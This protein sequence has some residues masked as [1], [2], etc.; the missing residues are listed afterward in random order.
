MLYLFGTDGYAKDVL[1]IAAL[2]GFPIGGTIEVPEDVSDASF[3]SAIARQSSDGVG[4]ERISAV[5]A[6]EDN[7]QRKAL[8]HAFENESLPMRFE[9]LIHPST[10]VSTRAEIGDGT[11]LM[12]GS[13]VNPDARIGRHCIVRSK[14]VIDPDSMIADFVHI[15]ANVIIQGDVQIGE[16]THIHTGAKITKGI[17][18]GR[19]CIIEA[20]AV[21]MDNVPDGARVA[22]GVENL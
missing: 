14:V 17:Y 18:I 7:Q 4:Q 6:I 16:G 1:E 11:V 21:V 9:T 2:Q 12:A 15:G 5:T 8:V 20:G 19:W 10:R 22:R 3:R 13:H